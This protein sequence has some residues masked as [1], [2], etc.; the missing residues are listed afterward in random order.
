VSPTFIVLGIASGLIWLFFLAYAG[1]VRSLRSSRLG[2]CVAALVLGAASTIPTLV[3][4][5]WM[6]EIVGLRESAT[7]QGGLTY[8]IASV[9]LREELCKLVFFL[10]VALLVIR[11]R[12]PLEMLIVAGCVGLGFAAEENVSYF[13]GS[14]G[15]DAA[16]RFLTAN[17]G[18][19]VDTGLIGFAFCRMWVEPNR[20]TDFFLTFVVI[21]I[22]HGVYDALI[23][24]P[25]LE[26]YGPLSATIYV[27]VAYFFFGE[28]R[29]HA[30]LG[31]RAVPLTAVFVYGFVTLLALSVIG[32]SLELGFTGA[33]QVMIPGTLGAAL[34][35]F[36]FFRQIDE[37]LLP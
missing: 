26:P 17:F 24:V 11:R 35:V 29:K 13:A 36:V 27:A 37:P 33:L 28:L 1:D 10:P 30:P 25:P 5:V 8:F 12:D 7:L 32:A 22:G 6:E 34:F 9:G 20:I 21:V 16:G 18:H 23:I 31:R 3:L 19:V 4:S 2:L 15:G 14:G